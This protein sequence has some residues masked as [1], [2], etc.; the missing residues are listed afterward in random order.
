MKTEQPKIKDRKSK[1]SMMSVD[2]RQKWIFMAT[3]TMGKLMQWST[4]RETT[5]LFGLRWAYSSVTLPI[6]EFL[7]N[8]IFAVGDLFQ[9]TV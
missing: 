6:N 3:L 9:I 4:C 8:L 5:A 2:S 7:R 1:I